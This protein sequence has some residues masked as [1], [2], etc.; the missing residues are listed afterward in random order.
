MTNPHT[1]FPHDTFTI[2]IKQKGVNPFELTPSLYGGADGDRTRDLLNAREPFLQ[3]FPVKKIPATKNS[4]L[5][6]TAFIHMDN[7]P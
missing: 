7:S 1:Q 4:W 5:T 6:N 2:Q 3:S